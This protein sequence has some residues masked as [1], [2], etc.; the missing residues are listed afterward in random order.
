MAKTIGI[1][2][3]IGATL[4]SSVAKA[5]GAVGNSIERTRAAMAAA[6][7][8]QR[9]MSRAME[10][11][12]KRDALVSQLRASPGNERLSRSLAQVSRQ[13]REAMVAARGYG[14]TAKTL[15]ASHDQASAALDRYNA[16]LRMQ[17][18]LQEASQKRTEFYGRAVGTAMS[19]MAMAQPLKVGIGFEEAMSKVRAISGASAAD[20]QAMTAQ[21]RELGASTVW[22]AKEAAE[23]MT[24]LSMAGFN[25]KQT[26][27][28][29]PGMLSLASA[30]AMDLGSTADIASNILTGFGFKAEQMGYVSDVLAKTFTRSNTKLQSLGD[31]FKYVG[32]AAANAGQSFQDT[33]AMIGKL[34]DAGIQGQ[35]A[36]TGLSAIISRMAGPPAEARKALD[37]LGVSIKGAHGTMKP[38][39][40]LFKELEAKMRNMGE[41]Q[42]IATAK[43]LFGTEHFAKGLILMKAAADG[44]IQSMSQSL[45]EQGYASRVASDQT[46]NLSG[47]LKGLNS[48]YEE[49][50]ISLYTAVAPALR[51][52]VKGLTS[53][54]R[55]V[56]DFVKAHPQLV[57]GLA[58]AAAGFIGLKT[59]VLGTQMAF[60]AVKPG[61]SM[62]GML[63]PSLGRSAATAAVSSTGLGGALRG[64]AAIGPAMFN[65]VTAGLALVA[66]GL[67]AL[68]NNSDTAREA[69][70][71]M[72]EDAK[73]AA[74]DLGDALGSVW[75][76]F[77][78]GMSDA[79]NSDF[80]KN[81]REKGSSLF[82]RAMQGISDIVSGPKDDVSKAEDE[83]WR[84]AEAEIEAKKQ[85]AASKTAGTSAGEFTRIQE[86]Y[87][88]AHPTPDMYGPPKPKGLRT[89]PAGL[90]KQP[91]SA[92]AP[93]SAPAASQ[94]Q[95][96]P[97]APAPAQS[98][99]APAQKAAPAQAPVV[100]STATFQFTINGMPAADFANGVMNVVK[101]HQ[102]DLQNMISNMVN[103]QVRK[104]YAAAG[105]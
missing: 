103:D 12:G 93:A 76:D 71:S 96:A 27:A 31:S 52:I 18:T 101:Q 85:A 40:V 19:A 78:K 83:K 87:A 102:N 25:A 94:S 84:K 17:N 105:N 92:S 98:A 4:S 104:M 73:Q 61:L 58:M 62:L 56:G 65:P 95:P 86:E 14:A 47:D 90:A 15:K 24:Y 22:S 26:M 80:M 46:D 100:N 66:G 5:F 75:D 10:L 39:P 42:R 79:W 2:F 21:A 13:Y 88:R 91:T 28:A 9:V 30:G 64:I 34:G 70:D 48:A 38:M 1:G 41:A 6:T 60:W 7:K 99:P 35:Q 16:K 11:Q 20:L 50:S 36:G 53:A 55:A 3:A 77:S 97:S 68:Y 43:A 74:A 69:M 54:M 8:Q 81:L 23:G 72:F 44:S 32:P 51:E 59:A 89:Q 33:A 49:V 45:Y 57:Q 63:L 82:T 29:M 67:V 37:K